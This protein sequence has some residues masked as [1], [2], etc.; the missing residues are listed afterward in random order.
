MNPAHPIG[1]WPE[2]SLAAIDATVAPEGWGR[3][4]D[5][6]AEQVNAV[7]IFLFVYDTISHGI[8]WSKTSE[9][10]RT[11]RVFELLEEMRL[12]GGTEDLPAFEFMRHVKPGKV[13]G[14][15][16]FF[17]IPDNEPLPPS[18]WRDRV[19]AAT[20]GLAR[21]SMRLNEFGPFTDLATTL[22]RTAHET[23]SE[24]YRR[25]APFL[26]PLLART[27]EASRTIASLTES[28]ARLMTLFDRLD[29]GVAF[30]RPDGKILCEN[31]A[32]RAIAKE[33]DAL[34]IRNGYLREAN[35]LER[36]VLNKLHAATMSAPA[37]N[38]A[39]STTLRR[40]SGALPLVVKSVQIRDA[41]LAREPVIMLMVLDPEDCHRLNAR[42][43]E[44]FGLLTDAEL[45]VCELLVRGHTTTDISDTRNTSVET[46]KSQIKST[47]AK[48]N[49]ASRM[50]ILRLAMATRLPGEGAPTET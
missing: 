35:P 20:G 28:Y 22:D 6:V 16:E 41:E 21:S 3:L 26:Q 33:W 17:S 27:L 30:L 25:F 32:L 50:D 24:E 45:E 39:L 1:L 13:L 23:G 2:I 42:G 5:L 29:F 8:D 46:T 47:A 44:A 31:N 11:D 37:A 14:E 9:L 12:G 34:G 7:G 48:L 10:G 19:L 36:G 49:C 15:R 40:L 43:L 4:C 18:D 38:S